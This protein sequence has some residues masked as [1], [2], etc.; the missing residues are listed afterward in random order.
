VLGQEN[1]VDAGVSTNWVY[2]TWHEPS[3]KQSLYH[4]VVHLACSKTGGRDYD[5]VF[6]NTWQH[7]T[8][9]SV[10][11]WDGKTDLFYY[12]AGL[13]FSN[14]T[15]GP[16]TLIMNTNHNGQCGAW[17][18]L[19]GLALWA[20]GRALW[21]L[22]TIT[23]PGDANYL[24]IKEWTFGTTNFNH[25]VFRWE[26]EVTKSAGSDPEM[27]PL[28]GVTG[29]V[30][31]ADGVAGQNSPTPAEKIFTSHTVVKNARDNKYYD[32]S[33][34]KVYTDAADFESQAIAGYARKNLQF[35]NSAT[36]KIQIRKPDAGLELPSITP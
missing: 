15:T 27:V 31:P 9:V 10:K 7:F 19:F 28:S 21:N 17:A 22:A 29:P 14:A 32:P 13:T 20:N 35:T 3:S 34:G 23:P 6:E 26:D 8:N 16:G 36:M 24:V 18:N 4:T 25:P 2:V 5:T 12:K 1:Y 30:A 33:Y 11:T